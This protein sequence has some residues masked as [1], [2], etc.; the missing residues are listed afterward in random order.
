MTKARNAGGRPRE[1]RVDTSIAQAVVAVLADHGYAGLTMDAVAT[2][3]GVSR[4]A[5]YRRYA[6]KQE[7]AFTVLLHDLDES[8]PADSGSLRG[9]LCALTEEIAAQV[10][11]S[12]PDTL[13]GLLADIRADP[14]LNERFATTYLSVERGIIATLLDRAVER[15]EL[16]RRPDPGVVQA[17]LLGP[18]YAW[19][20]V[21]DDDPER[22]PALA[23]LVAGM[24]TE[25]LTAGLL[26]VQP[27]SRR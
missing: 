13:H 23:Q 16:A 7:M 15:G 12:G 10:S 1:L 14:A 20:I 26:P 17:L 8:A 27:W 21:L 18:L 25:A 24:V 2:R 5:I 19:L 6:N 3:A 22:A 4:A 9:D 11:A